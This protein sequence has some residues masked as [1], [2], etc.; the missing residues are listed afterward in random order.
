MAKSVHTKLRE[1]QKANKAKD[2][3]IAALVA[4]LAASKAAGAAAT[5]TAT[6]ATTTAATATTTATTAT[7]AASATKKRKQLPTVTPGKAG[8]NKNAEKLQ[9]NIAHNFD[10]LAQEFSDK[11]HKH[12]A[13]SAK[14]KSKRDPTSWKGIIKNGVNEHIWPHVKCVRGTKNKISIARELIMRL[15]VPGISDNEAK[16]EDWVNTFF[17]EVSQAL[18]SARGEVNSQIKK[19]VVKWQNNHE[20]KG[21]TE[22]EL[23]RC[24]TRKLDMKNAEDVKLSVWYVN[25]FLPKCCAVQYHFNKDRRHYHPLSSFKEM[26]EKTEAFGVTLCL[27]NMERWNEQWKAKE[28]YRT[29]KQIVM[30]LKKDKNGNDVAADTMVSGFYSLRLP[31]ILRSLTSFSTPTAIFFHPPLC[32]L[33]WE[34]APK[35]PPTLTLCT[36]TDRLFS[37]STL[38]ILL[39]KSPMDSRGKV[40]KNTSS[41]SLSTKLPARQRKD[42]SRK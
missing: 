18:N 42:S 2:D 39:V 30:P 38:T 37:P 21:P 36:A 22:E 17:E 15:K 4:E 20:G 19:A 7:T 23:M 16:V 34:T 26:N 14:K 24:L 6:T 25:D 29:L 32:S 9:A 35:T 27:G 41:S 3:R 12:V 13:K 11:K 33:L 28:K 1:E 31:L 40:S 5:S 8:T 10:V